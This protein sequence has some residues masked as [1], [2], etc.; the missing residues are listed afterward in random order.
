M[1]ISSLFGFDPDYPVEH[2]HY[3]NF[4]Y[5]NMILNYYIEYLKLYKNYIELMSKEDTQIDLVSE[6]KKSG[7]SINLNKCNKFFWHKK[8]EFCG[9]YGNCDLAFT[10]PGDN[11]VYGIVIRKEYSESITKLFQTKVY[12]NRRE[13]TNKDFI[14]DVTELLKS[15]YDK[16]PNEDYDHRVYN[17]VFLEKI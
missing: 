3:Y 17:F 11:M 15:I 5:D 13:I 4:K 2:Y 16:L 6:E 8:S 14:K 10:I 12:I 9:N 1:N 7:M